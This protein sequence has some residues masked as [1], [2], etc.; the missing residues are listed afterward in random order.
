M[1]KIPICQNKFLNQEKTCKNQLDNYKGLTLNFVNLN[2]EP[3]WI[4]NEI[5]VVSSVK[6]VV[7]FYS[8]L[9]NNVIGSV[10][11]LNTGAQVIAYTEKIIPAR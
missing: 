6:L 3:N 11:P 10:T 9:A 5:R 2:L 7:L 4:I 1:L 8:P